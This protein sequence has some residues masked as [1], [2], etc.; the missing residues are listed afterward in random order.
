MLNIMKVRTKGLFLSIYSKG[1]FYFRIAAFA[2]IIRKLI[3]FSQ[4]HL[5]VHPKAHYRFKISKDEQT[6]LLSIPRHTYPN[7][8]CSRRGMAMVF[9]KKTYGWVMS[10]KLNPPHDRENVFFGQGIAINSDGTVFAVSAPNDVDQHERTVGA[11]YIFKTDGQEFSLIDYIISPHRERAR[12]GEQ[13]VLNEAGSRLLV[14]TP[15]WGDIHSCFT[16][17]AVSLYELCGQGYDLKGDWHADDDDERYRYIVSLN[18]DETQVSIID[19]QSRQMVDRFY[20]T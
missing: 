9:R 19:K 7:D 17:K 13:I 12:F 3:K 15:R 16:P 10:R 5:G 18:S 14:I 11:I 1:Y 4:Y 20:L 2:Q 8:R 6:I